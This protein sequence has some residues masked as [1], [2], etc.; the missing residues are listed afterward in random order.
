[1]LIPYQ[2]QITAI[3]PRSSEEARPNGEITL[4]PGH[5]IGREHTLQT[6]VKW[7]RYFLAEGR[8]K[9]AQHVNVPHR[10]YEGLVRRFEYEDRFTC[11]G[12]ERRAPQ[13]QAC[14]HRSPAICLHPRQAQKPRRAWT[15]TIDAEQL[16]P[17][18]P[19]SQAP[20]F[21]QPA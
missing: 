5:I 6:S 21:N 10:H 20:S 8:S 3:L 12:H 2:L 16:E 1:M 11:C 4:M 9:E 19:R 17:S 15:C 7:W 13:P 18:R 14:A